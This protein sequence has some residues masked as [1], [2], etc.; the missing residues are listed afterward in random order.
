MLKLNTAVATAVNGQL[1]SSEPCII[2]LNLEISK[3]SIL[4]L[5]SKLGKEKSLDTKEVQQTNDNT[6]TSQI[7][8]VIHE[9]GV[10]AHIMGYR[11]LKDA[12]SLAITDPRQHYCYH[13]SYL[14]RSCVKKSYYTKQS[15]TCYPSRH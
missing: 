3:D 9:I 5:L 12:I 7:T 10:P 2:Q 15:R 11:Y 4:E 14:S 13:K 1:Q 8:S 6:L